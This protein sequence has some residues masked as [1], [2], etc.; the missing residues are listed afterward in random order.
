MMF[1]KKFRGCEL[2]IYFSFFA[3]LAF[4][5]IFAGFQNGSI[6]L[7]SVLLHEAAHLFVIFAAGIIPESVGISALGMR[8]CLPENL[9]LRYQDNIKISLAGPL[10]NLF[11]G[12]ICLASGFDSIALPNLVMGS[13]HLMPV[14]PLDGGTALAAFLYARTARAEL[15]SIAV[16][17]LFLIP[18]MTMGFIVIIQN[19]YNF[20][21]LALSVYLMLYMVM[22]H[23]RP[24]T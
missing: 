13:F 16:S 23:R 2:Q 3:L 21:L 15:I 7:I 20:S 24:M 22:K 6:I 11:V 1:S 17:C 8:I 12:G 18:V 14:E 4:C 19:P 5:N 9:Q 10:M